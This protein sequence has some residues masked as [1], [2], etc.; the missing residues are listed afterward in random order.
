MLSFQLAPLPSALH[1]NRC[2]AF[3]TR[4][5]IRNFVGPRNRKD[6]RS[7][8]PAKPVDS[9]YVSRERSVSL[10]TYDGS[11]SMVF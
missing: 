4:R 3:I 10:G 1:E 2:K 8:G 6:V 11:P 7:A 5:P 9:G